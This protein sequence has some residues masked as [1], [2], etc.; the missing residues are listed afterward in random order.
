VV[1][2]VIDHPNITGAITYHTYAGAYLRPYS[3]HPDDYFK[4]E[5]LWTYQEIGKYATKLTG[6]PAVSV[7][8]DFKYHPKEVTRGAFDD[9]LFDHLGV[10]A[11]TCEIWGPQQQAGI[12]MKK[13]GGASGG[14]QLIEWY[15]DHPVEDD[16]KLLKWSDEKLAGKGFIN[17]YPFRHPQL[18][19]VE[20]GGWH[21]EYCWRNPPP[22]LL[23]QEIAPH[24]DFIIWHAAISPRIEFKDVIVEMLG[25]GVYHIRAVVQN[26]GWLPTSVS[27]RAAEKKLV[28]PL[29]IEIE[30]PA[31]ATLDS[32]ERR[33]EAGQLNG[34]ALK[35]KPYESADPTD[36]RVKVDWVVRAPAGSAVTVKAVS[37]RAGTITRRVTL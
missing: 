33:V 9:W 19:E 35:L 21:D 15:R 36:D 34:R 3:A 7:F 11:W 27:G 10:Y 6:Y 1:Q 31:G 22:H 29:E 16:L 2:F 14:F 13:P 23:E 4:T 8:H 32:G 28:R 26:T 25:E 20:L 5:D 18:G 24:A 37:Q 12:E 17:W 30:L